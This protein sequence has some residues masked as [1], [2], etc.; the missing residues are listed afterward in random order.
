MVC[1]HLAP[2]WS[3]TCTDHSDLAEGPS[4]IPFSDT[5]PIPKPLT[6]GDL[7]KLEDA[8]VAAIE[9]CKKIGCMRVLIVGKGFFLIY[10]FKLTL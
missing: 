8:F 7:E 3:D 4:D 2:T 6:K 5:Y 10:T 1:S 9:R